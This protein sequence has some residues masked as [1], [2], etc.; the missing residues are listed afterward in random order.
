MIWEG[1]Q[2]LVIGAFDDAGKVA[3]QY[4]V[5]QGEEVPP[6]ALALLRKARESGML[7]AIPQ[8][9]PTD[10]AEAEARLKQFEDSKH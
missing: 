9:D 3:E 1:S 7:Y 5:H 4:T 2:P 8:D 6:G 10:M